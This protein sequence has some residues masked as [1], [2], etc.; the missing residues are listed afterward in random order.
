MSTKKI[1]DKMT[2][3]AKIYR[4]KIKVLKEIKGEAI[5]ES[6]LNAIEENRE[7]FKVTLAKV[8][9]LLGVNVKKP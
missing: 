1:N 7:A 3:E 9:T 2:E 5:D 8:G 4:D 6:R